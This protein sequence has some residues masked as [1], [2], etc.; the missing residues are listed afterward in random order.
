MNT[1]VNN[2]KG[3]TV[4]LYTLNLS[5]FFEYMDCIY[6][7]LYKEKYMDNDDVLVWDYTHDCSQKLDPYSEVIPLDATITINKYSEI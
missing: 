6:Q 3:N 5:A 7:V 1:I 4:P 2:L